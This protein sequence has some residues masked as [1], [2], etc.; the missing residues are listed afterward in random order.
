M[1]DDLRRCD[2]LRMTPEELAIRAALGAVEALGGHPLLTDTV[3]FLSQAQRALADYIDDVLIPSRR[4]PRFNNEG[5]MSG[6]DGCYPA[7]DTGPAASL[8]DT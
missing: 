7:S 6:G 2:I 1:T 3:V 8:A 5:D 4:G